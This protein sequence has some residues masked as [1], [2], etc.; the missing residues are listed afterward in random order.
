MLIRRELDSDRDAVR[1]VHLA[2]FPTEAEAD[3]AA[4]LRTGGHALPTLSLVAVA[5]G[6]MN[7]PM[8]DPTTDP[9]IGHVVCSRGD[10]DG[11]AA[12]G[13]G[14]IGVLP[15]RQGRGVG[16]A[17]MHAVIGAAD[18]LDEPCVA[19]LGNPDLY[20]RF[21]FVASTEHGITPPDAAWTA[22]FQVR[23]LAAWDPSIGGTF[24]YAAPFDDV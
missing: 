4:S 12:L 20:R 19:L 3:L 8:T 15:A 13:L 10:V 2:A 11:R 14:P 6:P 21:G 24:H 17:L 16:T 9:V 23:T 7:G 5:N 1:R 18:A 22:F